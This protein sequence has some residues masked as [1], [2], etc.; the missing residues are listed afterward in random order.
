MGPEE[1]LRLDISIFDRR[2]QGDI[3]IAV[4]NEH[5]L[6]GFEGCNPATY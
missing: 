2:G 5:R 1:A 4:V 6:V 3:A